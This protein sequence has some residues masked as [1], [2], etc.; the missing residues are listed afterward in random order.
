MWQLR[1]LYTSVQTVQDSGIQT[2]GTI[3]CKSVQ[4]LAHADDLDFISRTLVD[5]KEALLS[6]VQAAEDMGLKIN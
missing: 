3:C 2:R 1:K 5:L 4:L 6:L